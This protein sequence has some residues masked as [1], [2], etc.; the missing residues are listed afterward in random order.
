MLEL[1]VDSICFVSRILGGGTA[2]GDGREE[3]NQ[4]QADVSERL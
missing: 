2:R 4:K 3:E 1:S